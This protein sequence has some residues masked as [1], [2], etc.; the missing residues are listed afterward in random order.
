MGNAGI[1]VTRVLYRK[2]A[3]DKIFLVTD[4]GMNDLL[5]P[6]FYKAYHAVQPVEN[7]FRESV[8]A[9]IVGPICESS[10]FSAQ[11][12]SIPDMRPNELLAIMGAGAYSFVMSSNYCSRPR[13][14][15][16]MVHGDR[17]DIVRQRETLDDLTRGEQLPGWM[18]E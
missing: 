7:S 9:D 8:V 1:L 2:Q 16:V 6:A 12:R 14:A 17:F 13:V 3:V 10:D 11:D 18:D 5:R 15:E 4:A